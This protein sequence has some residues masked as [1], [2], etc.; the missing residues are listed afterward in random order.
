M[1]GGDTL[2]M[3]VCMYVCIDIHGLSTHSVAITAQNLSPVIK[4]CRNKYLAQ[5]SHNTTT[6]DH[7][8]EA[9]SHHTVKVQ[10]NGHNSYITHTMLASRGHTSFITQYCHKRS[11]LNA[12]P[13]NWLLVVHQCHSAQPWHLAVPLTTQQCCLSSTS[14]F[15][16]ALLDRVTR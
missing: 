4:A 3:Y 8:C 15:G 1:Y 6:S 13:T 11:L 2:G 14:E 9:Y 10:H 16:G 5:Q 7:T 12:T